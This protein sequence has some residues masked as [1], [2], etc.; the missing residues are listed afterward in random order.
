MITLEFPRGGLV[1]PRHKSYNLFLQVEELEGKE[2]ILIWMFYFSVV[3]SQPLVIV[4]RGGMQGDFLIPGPHICHTNLF[5]SIFFAG[6]L[7]GGGVCDVTKNLL[8]FNPYEIH[9]FF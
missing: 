8:L 9:K 1:Y 6:C 4:W 2:E 3:L 5:I 7:L